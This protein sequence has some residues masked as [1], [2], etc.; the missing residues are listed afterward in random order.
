MCRNLLLRRQELV[1]FCLVLLRKSS[2]S[3]HVCL[4]CCLAV[5]RESLMC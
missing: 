1:V 2:V 3:V 5:L 4:N